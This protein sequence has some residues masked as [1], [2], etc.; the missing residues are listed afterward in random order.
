MRSKMVLTAVAVAALMSVA[1]GARA[2]EMHTLTAHFPDDFK[3]RTSIVSDND[4]TM[5]GV[6]TQTHSKIVMLTQMHKTAQGYHATLNFE[7]ADVQ[8]GGSAGTPQ[9]TMAAKM[10]GLMT[11]VGKIE[12]T[13]DK[14]LTPLRIDNMDDIKAKIKAAMTDDADPQKKASGEAVYNM[15]FANLTPESAAKFLKQMKQSGMVFNRPLPLGTEVPMAGDPISVMGSTFR[16]SGTIKL[17]SWIEGKSAHLVYV[18]APTDEDMHAFVVGML[19][20][21]VDRMAQGKDDKAKEM[22]ARMFDS[23]KMHM[24]STCDID[25]DLANTVNSHGDCTSHTDMTMDLRKM[26][27][28]EEAKASP[29]MASQLQVISMTQSSHTVTD[30]AVVN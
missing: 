8:M 19:K 11:S 4:Q 17:T 13:Y 22:M 12:A 1:G 6:A 24:V 3:A 27:T 16:M 25:V 7:S 2:Q 18:I 20:N 23:V 15:M 28:E 21:M 10:S 14:D 9:A 26:L 29:Q 5:Q 30:S